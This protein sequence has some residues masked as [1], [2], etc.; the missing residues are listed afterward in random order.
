MRSLMTSL[1]LMALLAASPVAAQVEVA[2]LAAP[3]YF[4]LGTRDAAVPADLWRGTSP[5]LARDLLPTIGRKPLS[6]AAAALARR[7]LGASAMGPEGVGRDPAMAAARVQALL[8][9]GDPDAAWAAV[10]RAPGQSASAALSQAAA[11]T[12]L[13]QGDEAAACQVSDQLSVD[14]GE[15][16][17]L[18]L[19]AFCQARAGQ[20][21][22]AQLTLTLAS[23]KGRDPVL[24]RLLGAMIA[25]AGD[26]G[27]ASARNGLELALSRRLALDI[28]PALAGAPPAIVTMV[29]GVPAPA[30]ATGDPVVDIRA[31]VLAGDV[32]RA[33]AL[34]AGLIQDQPGVSATGLAMLDALIAAAAGQSDGPTL[35]RLVERGALEGQRSIG[36]SA[37]L[38]FSALGSP[39]DPLARAEFAR[40]DL[41]RNAAP[42]ARLAALDIA[43]AA[44][45]KGE[46]ALLAVAIAADLGPTGTWSPDRARIIQAL[47]RVGL[48]A[49]ARAFAI[50]GLLALPVK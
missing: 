18:R 17:W 20:A 38:L 1:G 5:D 36:Q 19:R 35:D 24:S 15:L 47:R 27:P 21:D 10:E 45:L 42:A 22:A 2:P 46:T 16:Y 4:S 32:E 48:E 31:A 12:A 34:R 33:R 3:D 26:P 37:A 40:F 9:L 39:M 8:A 30:G 50:E 11:E 14:R 7:V 44:G 25:G 23:E 41:G 6:P 29:R 49:D 43:A 13:I 28:Q